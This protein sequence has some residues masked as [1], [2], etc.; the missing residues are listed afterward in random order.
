MAT[1]RKSYCILNSS[2]QLHVCHVNAAG[3]PLATT[4]KAPKHYADT[5]MAIPESERDVMSRP[6][7]SIT[8][9]STALTG[10]RVQPHEIT[11]IGIP[12]EGDRPTEEA[13]AHR[14]VMGYRLRLRVRG[15]NE[16]ASEF[17]TAVDDLAANGSDED[18]SLALAAPTLADLADIVSRRVG[19]QV[20]PRPL[21]QRLRS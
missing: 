4:R 14:D 5:Q 8:P 10:V 9:A 20:D 1:N 6:A 15:N 7:V 2:G 18:V 21:Y 17:R 13:D 16:V 3:S 12:W 11:V 19:H